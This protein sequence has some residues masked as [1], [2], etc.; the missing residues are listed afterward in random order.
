MKNVYFILL[1]LLSI[2]SFHC[3]KELGYVRQNINGNSFLTGNAVIQGNIF[4]ENGQP[5]IGAVIKSGDKTITT[6]SHGYFRIIGSVSDKGASLITAEKDGYF[7]AY[8]SFVPTSGVNQVIIKLLRKN[9]SGDINSTTG[10]NVS[11]SD[12]SKISLAA[13]SVAKATGEKYAGPVRIFATYIDPTSQDISQT[14]PGSL[15]ADNKD[16]NRV[17]LTSYGMLAVQLESSTGE[18]LQIASGSTATLIISIPSPIQSSAPNSIS[19]WYVDEQTGTW[20]EEG[21]A[22]GMEIDTSEK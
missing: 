14:I 5:A 13:N 21:T 18:K 12:G 16:G 1:G 17:V 20:K 6:D 10:G 2:I 8:R 7:K 15:M 9:L 11:L 3:Q 22:E 4:D 19:L